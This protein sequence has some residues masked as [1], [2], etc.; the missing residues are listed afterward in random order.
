MSDEE[1]REFISHSDLNWDHL[2]ADFY[3]GAFIGDGIQGAMIMGDEDDAGAL[4]MLLGRYD[5]ISHT[6][7][8]G[9]E[10]FA[11]RL[12]A[13]SIC[14]KPQ[15]HVQK[16]SMRLNLWDGE[17]S[18]TTETEHGGFAWRAFAE[19]QNRVMVVEV[20]SESAHSLPPLFVRSE[21]AI[22]PRFYL[23]KEATPE[24]Y[25]EYLPPEA[26]CER[27][28]GTHFIVQELSQKGAHVVAWQVKRVSAIKEV[29][30]VAIAA[31]DSA[32]RK[33]AAER[34]RKDASQRLNAAL[35]RGEAALMADHRQWWHAYYR[36][37]YLSLPQDPYWQQ[38]WWIQLYKFG[39]ASA[40][41]SAFLID[42]E[43]PWP[44]KSYW[45]GIWW[46]LNLQLSYFP[47]FS[48]NKLKVG[49]SLIRGIDR[50]YASGFFHRSASN[51]VGITVGRTSHYA[52]GDQDDSHAHECGNFTWVLHDY[53]KYWKYSDDEAIG[54]NLFPLLAENA[55]YLLSKLE[56]G[57]DGKRHMVA[58]CSPEYHHGNRWYPDTNYGLMA[59]RWALLTLCTMSKEL[60]IEDARRDIWQQ[61]LDELVEYPVD[62]HGLMI[63]AQHGYSE[64]HRHYSHLMAIYP[65]HTLTTEQ[66]AAEEA[67]V[68]KSVERWLSLEEGLTGFAF[69]GGCAMRATLGDGNGALEILER[70]KN[71]EESTERGN[72]T[73]TT[74]YRE[75]GGPVIETPL[76]A[77][78]SINYML[79][80]SWGG[81]IRVFPAVPDR[82]QDLHFSNLRTEG[83]CLVSGTRKEGKNISLTIKSERAK[84]VRIHHGL[85]CS[86]EQ[87]CITPATAYRILEDGLFE[88]E[89]GAESEITVTIG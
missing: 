29:L 68:K 54:R 72:V 33:A 37:S 61:A 57:D 42:T 65:Y 39:S 27:V 17:A 24:E 40:E 67:L 21:R 2:T 78:E 38:F 73:F 4:R 10:G 83:G 87:L 16:R 47:A 64:S 62:E 60:E 49:R 28:N 80:Q 84:K 59:L 5:V 74:M 70:L 30:F 3:N 52:G 43:G 26:L 75:N 85:S 86:D 76:S 50:L 25:A 12:F 56:R 41:D 46:N 35:Q 1:W 55:E 53:W 48:A 88:I 58:T 11:S 69:T 51:G 71:R 13:G 63:D 6:P 20:Q 89:V 23:A 15:T 31:D 81:T 44:W 77:V 18:G 79:L 9:F 22:S 45:G 14:I 8:P 66:G 19:R 34:A 82:W 36:E 7:I 32:D